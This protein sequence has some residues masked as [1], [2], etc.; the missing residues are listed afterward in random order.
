MGLLTALKE[1]ELPLRGAYQPSVPSLLSLTAETLTPNIT[2]KVATV[3]L[4]L[5]HDRSEQFIPVS[6]VVGVTVPVGATCPFACH[7]WPLH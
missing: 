3:L 2:G 5:S 1:G 4:H 7:L 6:L